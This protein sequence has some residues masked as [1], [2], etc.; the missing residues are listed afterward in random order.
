MERPHLNYRRLRTAPRLPRVLLGMVLIIGGFLGF[1]PVL[2]FW[3]IPLGLAVIF[4]DV[5]LVRRAWSRLRAW[6]KASTGRN[7][8]TPRHG[9]DPRRG[10]GPPESAAPAAVDARNA[11]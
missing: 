2:G 9:T 10:P 1:L 8:G 7:A 3:M 11:G 4:L 5:P 6:W